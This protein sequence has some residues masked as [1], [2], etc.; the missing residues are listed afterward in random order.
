MNYNDY[1]V[2]MFM[3]AISIQIVAVEVLDFTSLLLPRQ[4]DKKKQGVG[5]VVGSGLQKDSRQRH[6]LRGLLVTRP[7][8]FKAPARNFYRSLLLVG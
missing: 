2:I 5:L 7:N 8:L 6:N 3:S 1:K 4:R